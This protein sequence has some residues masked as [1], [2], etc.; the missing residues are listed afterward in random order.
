MAR[1]HIAALRANAAG[2]ATPAVAAQALQETFGPTYFARTI[3]SGV[4]WSRAVPIYDPG[5]FAQTIG[6]VIVGTPSGEIIDFF[7]HITA[8][9]NLSIDF[10]RQQGPR[11]VLVQAP[12]DGDA[13][14]R[15]RRGHAGHAAADPQRRHHLPTSLPI[16]SPATCPCCGRTSRHRAR[17]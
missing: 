9:G 14:H 8:F 2:T 6:N 17:S 15:R 7:D 12:G 3:N 13:D 11:S 1:N 5:V 16:R 4:S 10:E